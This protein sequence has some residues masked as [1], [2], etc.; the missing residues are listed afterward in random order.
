MREPAF[1]GVETTKSRSR[2]GLQSLHGQ[3]FS[4]T[5]SENCS[6]NFHC[7]G[8][9]VI[10]PSLYPA[11]VNSSKAAL[12]VSFG[13]VLLK[14]LKGTRLTSFPNHTDIEEPDNRSDQ[15]AETSILTRLSTL[16][17]T[18]SNLVFLGIW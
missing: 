2:E 13:P 9:R 5:N 18:K 14:Q 8:G 3:T 17:K 10:C 4:R 6:I 12:I 15:F 16:A 11:L 7:C 1:F